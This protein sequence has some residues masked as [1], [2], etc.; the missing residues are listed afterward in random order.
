MSKKLSLYQQHV[1]KWNDCQLCS[2]C[3][4]R[5]KVI[6][7]RG[8][9]PS[10]VLFI[11]DAPGVS[12][13][14]LGRPFVGPAGKLLDHIIDNSEIAGNFSYALTTLVGCAPKELGNAKGES[15]KESILSCR[16]KLL[17]LIELCRPKILVLVG[18]VAQK[19]T[20]HIEGTKRVNIIHPAAILCMD[21]SQQSLA[22]KRCKVILSDA[23]ASNF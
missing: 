14:V 10:S 9:I 6:F 15:P 8:K 20:P 3:E 18:P 21:I 4:K 2:L 5:T 16:T 7:A 13:D 12:E 23:I 22:I 17:E 1:N 19:Q 11:G